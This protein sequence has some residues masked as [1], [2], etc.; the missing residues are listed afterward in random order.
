MLS[1]TTK[2]NFEVLVT[3]E[4][5]SHWKLELSKTPAITELN[6]GKY[7]VG[8]LDGITDLKDAP[9]VV[10]PKLFLLIVTV[11]LSTSSHV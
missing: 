9:V 10:L 7:R 5:D 2:A 6:L 1:R 3:L 8:L 4:A 11:A